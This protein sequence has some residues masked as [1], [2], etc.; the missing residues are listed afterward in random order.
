[1]GESLKCER[2]YLNSRSNLIFRHFSPPVISGSHTLQHPSKRHAQHEMMAH[3]H[4]QQNM[5]A[6]GTHTLGRL[7]SHN[8]SPTH[9][10]GKNCKI[11]VNRI[12]PLTLTEFVALVKDLQ[13]QPLTLS[14]SLAL[15]P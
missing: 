3:V 15:F 7:P 6:M 5:R 1:M 14:H 4:M 2:F 8:H 9:L 10:S 11:T 13:K 12:H